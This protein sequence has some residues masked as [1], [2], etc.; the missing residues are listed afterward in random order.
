MQNSL[1]IPFATILLIHQ[2]CLIIFWTYREES[3]MTQMLR[4]VPPHQMEIGLDVMIQSRTHYLGHFQLD[5]GCD[6]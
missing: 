5:L 6:S 1:I 4:W 2:C 3:V